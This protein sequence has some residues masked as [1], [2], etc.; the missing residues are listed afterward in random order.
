MTGRVAAITAALLACAGC[1]SSSVSPPKA[2]TVSPGYAKPSAAP[3][4]VEYSVARQGAVTV[5]PPCDS[6]SF[7]V[8]RKD[9]SV[10]HDPYNVFI[11]PPSSLLRAAVRARLEADGRF[12][13]VMPQS[14]VASADVLVEV[15][16]SDLSLDCTVADRRV[17]HAAVSVDVL[18]ADRGA[19]TVILSGKGDSRDG[20]PDGGVGVV[21]DGDYTAAFSQAF[22]TALAG[23]LQSLKAPAQPSSPSIESKPKGEPK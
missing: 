6:V 10:V 11:S 16:V 12:G 8:C 3:R 17:A 19:R 2:W 9:G 21:K 5:L 7:V 22:D 23:A 4:P 20:N 18:R 1:L 15:L 13:R 14:S